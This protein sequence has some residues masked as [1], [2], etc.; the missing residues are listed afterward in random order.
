MSEVPVAEVGLDTRR[1]WHGT[2]GYQVYLRSFA[3]SNGDGIGDLVGIHGRL[4]YLAGLGVDF[5]WVTPFY[6]SPM[7]DWGYDVRSEEPRV[8]EEGRSRWSPYH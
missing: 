3:D 2:V 1:W 6:P 8:G 4:D 5:V 7:A